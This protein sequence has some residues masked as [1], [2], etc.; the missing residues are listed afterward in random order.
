MGD[1][2]R[3]RHVGLRHLQFPLHSLQA[4]RGVSRAA[5]RALSKMSS[6]VLS[7][8][9][10]VQASLNCDPASQR[11]RTS[12][13]SAICQA[14]PTTYTDINKDVHFSDASQSRRPFPDLLLLSEEPRATFSPNPPFK[15]SPAKHLISLWYGGPR[16]EAESCGMTFT[17]RSAAQPAPHAPIH[18]RSRLLAWGCG[19]SPLSQLGRISH[20]QDL[21]CV[22]SLQNP[23]P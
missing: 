1:G 17:G 15:L 16:P 19:A 6:A 5:C 12:S 20:A 10:T 21:H 11:G 8:Q 3:W 18:S 14:D 7:C 13:A 4:P 23:I 9:R 22:M 2:G